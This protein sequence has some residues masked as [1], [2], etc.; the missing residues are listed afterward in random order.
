MKDSSD[1]KDITIGVTD[2]RNAINSIPIE[3][4]EKFPEYKMIIKLVNQMA[5]GGYGV[6]EIEGKVKESKEY[7]E[8][9]K[10]QDEIIK[11]QHKLEGIDIE[12]DQ[13]YAEWSLKYTEKIQNAANRVY[14]DMESE[15]KKE[16]ISKNIEALDNVPVQWL[17]DIGYFITEKQ[18]AVEL[19]N[20]G[21]LVR[22][23]NAFHVLDLLA[24]LT[25]V[26]MFPRT[27]DKSILDSIIEN[28]DILYN[29]IDEFEKKY[30]IK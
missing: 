1:E 10:K 26:T 8:L 6:K 17:M 15:S 25:G 7:K 14:M 11:F 19:A 16:N 3:I 5:D 28:Q 9:G 4:I 12:K 20:I 18:L 13:E 29:Y 22:L 23:K 30:K 24:L 21:K 27:D 2:F